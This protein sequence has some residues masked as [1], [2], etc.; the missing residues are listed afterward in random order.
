[1][2]MDN[3]V[4]LISR[5]YILIIFL[6]VYSFIAIRR[7]GG[8]T[9]P[10]WLAMLSGAIIVLVLNVVSIEEAYNSIK[11]DII[12][13]LIGM[14]MITSILQSTGIL[15]LITIKILRYGNTY[16]RLLLLILV[17]SGVLSAFL[18]ND[19][20][21][22][23]LTPIILSIS[24]IGI[25]PRPLLI[26]LA[27]GI[28]IGSV[29]TPIG[30]PQNLL[31]ALESDIKAPMLSFSTY[32]LIPTIINY[33]ITYYILIYYYKVPDLQ[34]RFDINPQ[35]VLSTRL[36]LIIFIVIA[37][38]ISLFI[39]NILHILGIDTVIDLQHI[40]L[41]GALILFAIV[42]DKR[43]LRR[44]NWEI[45][46][47]FIGM[48]IF[49]YALIKS[50]T[51]TLFTPLLSLTDNNIIDITLASVILS[52]VMSNVPFV[53]FYINLLKDQGFD[54]SDVKEWLTLAGA[55]TL[56]GNLTIIGAVS[57]LIILDIA[58]N[59]SFRFI[60][61]FKIGSIV[62]TVNIIILLIFMIFMP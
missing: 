60:E 32:L 48:F 16:R 55:S 26:T 13:F 53:A 50:N 15:E 28:T 34:L 31:I 38:I 3:I 6:L 45:I 1:M 30:N 14:F 42:R 51:I 37:I 44:M 9:I 21:A 33:I 2:V 17:G 27:F 20:I 23:V 56:A 57:N 39:V 29:M 40:S 59:N 19:T 49:M 4:Y 58:K 35:Y 10:A 36:R 5:Y 18:M 43:V 24:K 54:S 12:I 41:I 52:Q 25:N 22:L 61:F 7:V 47:L 11:F 8:I 62:T 46:I